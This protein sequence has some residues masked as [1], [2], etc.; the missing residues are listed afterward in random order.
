V[1]DNKSVKVP[2]AKTEVRD[3]GKKIVGRKRQIA[4]GADGR[5]LMINLTA[6]DIADN[7]GAR[8]IFQEHPRV[9]V[10]VKLVVDGAYDWL[11]LMDKAALSRLY[12]RDHLTLRRSEGF[13]RL[14]PPSGLKRTFG[15]MTRW[16]CLVRNHEKRIDVSEAMIPVAMG[17][18]LFRRTAHR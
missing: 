11:E 17:G 16:R 12:D 7:V 5:L 15:W 4:V 8:V 2:H 18:V 9:L 14:A 6:A 1:T 3:A 13:P 10:L